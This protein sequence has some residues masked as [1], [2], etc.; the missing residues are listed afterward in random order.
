M[1]LR[2][3]KVLFKHCKRMAGV[4]EQKTRHFYTRFMREE[5]HYERRNEKTSIAI[6]FHSE[7]H[8]SI[9]G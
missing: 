4:V 7:H 3:K 1:F 6:V 9:V 2:F 5:W 8:A